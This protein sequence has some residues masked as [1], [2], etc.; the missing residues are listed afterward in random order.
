MRATTAGSG[1][2]FLHTVTRNRKLV[3]MAGVALMAVGVGGMIAV[4]ADAL[5]TIEQGDYSS[6]RGEAFQL[7]SYVFLFSLVAGLVAVIYA[8]V[9]SQAENTSSRR[10][11]KK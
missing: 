2:H 8:A 1:R 6:E 11:A 5:E 3:A 10:L 9:Y 7:N 4:G